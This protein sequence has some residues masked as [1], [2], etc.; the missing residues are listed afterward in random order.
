MEVC[1]LD[2]EGTPWAVASVAVWALKATNQGNTR[3]CPTQR[4]SPSHTSQL[5]CSQFSDEWPQL[6][7]VNSSLE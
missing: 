5:S 7:Q 4:N 3:V 2:G 1:G 6:R